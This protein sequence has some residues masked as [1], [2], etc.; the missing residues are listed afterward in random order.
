MCTSW[1]TGTGLFGSR[2]SPSHE[3]ARQGEETKIN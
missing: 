3:R 2:T 1:R